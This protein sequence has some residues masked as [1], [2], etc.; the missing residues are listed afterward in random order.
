MR[1]S[2]TFASMRVLPSLVITTIFLIVHTVPVSFSLSGEDELERVERVVGVD[3]LAIEGTL[4]AVGEV[5][6]PFYD[7]VRTLDLEKIGIYAPGAQLLAESDAGVETFPLESG[8]YRGVFQTLDGDR[9][10]ATLTIHPPFLGVMLRGSEFVEWIRTD[11]GDY[12]DPLTISYYAGRQKSSPADD[13]ADEPAALSSPS[14]HVDLAERRYAHGTYNCYEDEPFPYV[15]YDDIVPHAD[16]DYYDLKGKHLQIVYNSIEADINNVNDIF[17][18]ETCT[19]FR[20]LGIPVHTSAGSEVLTSTDASVLL[21]QFRTHFQG[22]HD[23]QYYFDLAHL[24][25]GKNL[26]GTT[27]GIAYTAPPFNRYALSQQVDECVGC[28]WWDP[29][30]D[31]TSFQRMILEAHEI[32]HNYRASHDD[33]T[34]H[35]CPPGGL[36][37]WTIVIAILQDFMMTDF[38]DA[39]TLTIQTN[40]PKSNI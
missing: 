3:A 17:N 9:G 28:W 8:S 26:D 39:N 4:K 37:D 30:Y 5:T 38:S 10:R 25:T 31:A 35:T 36:C 34:A 20:I 11:Y 13:E 40:R 24:F 32:A 16:Y 12:G 27:I 19:G 33:A 2:A 23:P 6:L 1:R 29:W 15:Y 18:E 14:N 21:P 22:V 7:G